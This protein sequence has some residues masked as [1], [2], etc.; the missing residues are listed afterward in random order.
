MVETAI[1]M[2]SLCGAEYNIRC[3]VQ[4]NKSTPNTSA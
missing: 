2:Y 1:D 3:E 4:L